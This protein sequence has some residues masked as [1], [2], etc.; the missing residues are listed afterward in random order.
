MVYPVVVLVTEPE[1]VLVTEPEPLVCV[2]ALFVTTELPLPPHA[3]SE[4]QVKKTSA[5]NKRVGRHMNVP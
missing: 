1:P 2:G 5:A 4:M 3:A